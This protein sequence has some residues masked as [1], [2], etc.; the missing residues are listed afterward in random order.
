MEAWES[1]SENKQRG[2]DAATAKRAA[3]RKE[4]KAQ[5]DAKKRAKEQVG[6]RVDTRRYRCCHRRRICSSCRIECGAWRQR[7]IAGGS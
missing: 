4:A 3:A 2:I 6:A 1:W 5:D 7:R